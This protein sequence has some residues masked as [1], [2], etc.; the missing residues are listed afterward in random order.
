MPCLFTN[1]AEQPLLKFHATFRSSR[2]KN[3]IVV[4]VIMNGF[5]YLFLTKQLCKIYLALDSQENIR[6]FC[7]LKQTK[8]REKNRGETSVIICGLNNF[9]KGFFV[10]VNFTVFL[11]QF[12][13]KNNFISNLFFGFSSF[14]KLDCFL[15]CFTS[16]L[17]SN[18][19]N[20]FI[21]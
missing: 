6:E 19:E 16:R 1:K 18:K 17:P 5:L 13:H 10:N 3:F 8:K 7:C 14:V 4:F 11:L 21:K 15:S 2:S 9:P 12:I 20:H